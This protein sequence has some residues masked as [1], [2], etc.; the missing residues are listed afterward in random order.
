MRKKTTPLHS[1]RGLTAGKKEFFFH[2]IKLSGVGQ[3]KNTVKEEYSSRSSNKKEYFR[4][5]LQQ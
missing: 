3:Q 5:F 2:Q 1:I 4:R